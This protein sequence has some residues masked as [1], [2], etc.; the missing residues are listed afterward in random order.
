MSIDNKVRIVLF[1]DGGVGKSA[2]TIRY[3]QRIFVGDYDPTIEDSYTKWVTNKNGDR[4]FL[5]VTDTAGQEA[6]VAIRDHYIQNGDGFLLVY[7]ITDKRSFQQLDHIRD[8]IQRIKN[9]KNVPILVCANKI[10]LASER[11]VSKE[12]GE[13]FAQRLDIDNGEK[14]KERYIETSA[15]SPADRGTNVDEAF[16]RLVEITHRHLKPKDDSS[17]C[18][19]IS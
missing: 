1:G 15:K 7:S 5:D 19:T 8:Q 6:F 13:E 11:E 10:D 17:S 18:C 12:E 14:G 3:F 9:T 16:S 4:I 2:L